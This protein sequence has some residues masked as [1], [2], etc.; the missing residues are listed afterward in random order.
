LDE[1]SMKIEIKDQNS[2]SITMSPT[3]IK[4]ESPLQIDIKAGTV[5]TLGAGVSLAISGPSL[6]MKADASV[7]IEGAS[8][9]L[10]AQG[11]NV[12]SGLPVMIN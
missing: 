8:A 2:N 5:L 1:S 9:K 7:S 4:M 3:G 6:S 11:P 12:I 10:A